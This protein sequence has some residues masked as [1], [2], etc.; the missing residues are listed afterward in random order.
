MRQGP[1][2]PVYLAGEAVSTLQVAGEGGAVELAAEGGEEA[3]GACRWVC[4]WCW[5]EARAGGGCGLV[6]AAEVGVCQYGCWVG[7]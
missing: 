1:D 6:V 7:A 5:M 2:A 3:E 4:V